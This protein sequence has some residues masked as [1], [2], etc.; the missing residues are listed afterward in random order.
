MKAAGETHAEWHGMI[1]HAC[2][3][4]G[5]ELSY[6]WSCGVTART[7]FEKKWKKPQYNINIALKSK[8]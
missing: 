5:T 3:Y 1:Q 8:F 2:E 6:R 7:L 4:H